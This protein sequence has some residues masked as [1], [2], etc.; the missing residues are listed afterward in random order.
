[1]AFCFDCMQKGIG[2]ST[3]KKSDNT[4]RFF[5]EIRRI[6]IVYKDRKTGKYVI[7]VNEK[8]LQRIRDSRENC[9]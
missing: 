1:M 5:L 3:L 8:G 6:Q 7:E 2:E 4:E 9:T